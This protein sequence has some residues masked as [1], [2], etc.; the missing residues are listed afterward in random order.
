[1]GKVIVIAGPT[2]S[3]KTSLSIN[4]AEKINSE[5]ISADSRQVYRYLNIGT[6]KPSRQ[7]LKN[8]KHHLIDHSNPDDD[9]NAGMFVEEAERIISR[10]QSENKIA[11]VTGGTG[12]YIK[13]L[14]D[15]IINSVDTNKE[16]RKELLNQRKQ[17]GNEYLYE[18]LKK[19]DAKSASTMLP[20]NWKRVMRALEVYFIS[21]KPIWQHFKEQQ[22]DE[23]NIYL[24][25]GLEWSRDQLYKRIEE[26]VDRMIERGL[27]DEVKLLLEKGYSKELN[28]LNTV[29]YKEIISYLENEIS[30][31]RAIEL[32]KRNTRRYSKRQITWFKADKRIN[33]IRI[34]SESDFSKASNYI[35]QKVLNE[36]KN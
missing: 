14:I 22:H 9:F 1:M 27:V 12:L 30:L 11:V 19:V 28:A 29:G 21:G 7:E 34:E 5:I 4:V 32:I 24:Q 3:G 31:D 15:G 25:Y 23:N 20:Q 10:L 18:Q 16:L 6:A 13:S 2:C 26:R 8:V 35:T 17:L 36:R 33:W